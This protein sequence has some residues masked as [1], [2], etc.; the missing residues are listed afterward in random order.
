VSKRRH[1][2]VKSTMLVV[3]LLG[4]GGR[5]GRSGVVGR[6]VCK[7]ETPIDGL[8]FVDERNDRC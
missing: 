2:K 4:F 8:F 3:L 7:V 1:E 5:S 6:S